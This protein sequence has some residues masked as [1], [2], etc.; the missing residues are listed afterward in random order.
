[1]VSSPVFSFFFYEPTSRW[2]MR[3][4]V[5]LTSLLF[6]VPLKRWPISFQPFLLPPTCCLATIEQIICWRQ[7]FSPSD[8]LLS[9]FLVASIHCF[10]PL[11]FLR[12]PKKI[13][14]V[15]F[16]FLFSLRPSPHF[17]TVDA[18]LPP[19]L[20]SPEKLLPPPVWTQTLYPF[21]FQR[22]IIVLSQPSP[23]HAARTPCS[24]VIPHKV[25][26]PPF[27]SE[28]AFEVILRSFLTPLFF[29]NKMLPFDP[30]SPPSFRSGHSTVSLWAPPNFELQRLSSDHARV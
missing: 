12:P 5:V 3:F 22:P 16:P 14:A 10:P 23:S 2:W 7:G 1:L 28:P 11:L 26:L 17:P 29:Q 21:Q 13:L 19:A 20:S 25:I 24:K 8:L 4:H 6:F 15:L 30:I 18:V 9:R 27:F